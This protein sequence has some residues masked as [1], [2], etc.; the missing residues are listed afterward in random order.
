[1]FDPRNSGPLAEDWDCMVIDLAVNEE[2][3]VGKEIPFTLLCLC[4]CGSISLIRQKI[5]LNSAAVDLCCAFVQVRTWL[6]VDKK[7][8]S[9]I[10]IPMQPMTLLPTGQSLSFLVESLGGEEN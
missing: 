6:Y 1:M 5:F 4:C 10:L 7:W 8:M 3:R 9:H 2:E